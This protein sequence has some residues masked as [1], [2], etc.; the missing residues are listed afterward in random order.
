MIFWITLSTIASLLDTPKICQISL[1]NLS[2]SEKIP[3]KSFLFLRYSFTY[4]W[5]QF[6]ALSFKN[7]IISKTWFNLNILLN[8]IHQLT[9]IIYFIN[10]FL[11]LWYLSNFNN[12]YSWDLLVYLNIHCT[13]YSNYIM[14][15]LIFLFKM[16]MFIDWL[17]SEILIF[18]DLKMLLVYFWNSNS[19]Q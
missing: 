7:L 8:L 9:Y 11:C 16:N 2:R 18:K 3:F 17:L 4:N 13:I 10:P 15:F 14:D 5:I 19:D 6:S 12:L 1:L